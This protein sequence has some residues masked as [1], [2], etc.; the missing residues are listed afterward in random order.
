[1]R[2]AMAV[3]VLVG[4]LLAAAACSNSTEKDSGCTDVGGTCVSSAS[5]GTCVEDT[6]PYACSEQGATCCRVASSSSGG[7]TSSSGSS[8]SSGST[9]SSGSSTSS[10]STSSS[11]SSTSSG[12]SSGPGDAASD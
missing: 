11:G 7:S 12:S 1:M 4:G 2:Y 3:L 6:L 5:L 10:G 9:S 8:T